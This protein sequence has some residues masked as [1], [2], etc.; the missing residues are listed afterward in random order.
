MEQS[1]NNLDLLL[2]GFA[3]IA[4][5][6]LIKINKI[7]QKMNG[8]FKHWDFVKL[9][10]ASIMISVITVLV[11]VFLRRE[12]EQSEYASKYMGATFFALGILA[13]FVVYKFIGRAQT[14]IDKRE[15]DKDISNTK[16]DTDGTI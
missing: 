8:G 13:Q 12:I 16:T 15:E 11:A 3:G 10:W 4:V 6:V 1:F 5:H 2:L 9:E 7:I 14:I